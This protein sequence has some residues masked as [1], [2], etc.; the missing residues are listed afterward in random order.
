MYMCK[1]L[2]KAAPATQILTA[3]KK[4]VTMND[5]QLLLLLKNAP[6]EGLESAIDLY[7]GQVRWIASKIIGSG[8]DQDVEEC[9][10]D[11]F[12]R[13]WQSI[14]RYEPDSGTPLKSYLF[15]IARHTAL[16]YRRRNEKAGELIPIE[17]NELEVNL[18]F[19]DEIACKTNEKLLQESIDSLGEPDRQIFILRYFL[20]ERI[21]A[22]AEHLALQPK[23]VE[24]K[25]YRG[26]KALRTALIERGI[27]I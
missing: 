20:G 13:L 24:N 23:T 2:Y 15:G 27:I 5:N 3:K 10:S 14:D 22:I 1:G 19:T 16:D 12:V 25:L 8:R 26:K 21:A 11:A 9:V 18:D 7:G 6:S 4:E 17:E